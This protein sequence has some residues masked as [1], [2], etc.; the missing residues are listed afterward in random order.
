MADTS[1]FFLLDLV[2]YLL[3]LLLLSITGWV[4]Y[5]LLASDLQFR[6]THYR[7]RLRLKRQ[8]LKSRESKLPSTKWFR[9]LYQLLTIGSSKSDRVSVYAFLG[10][11]VFIGFGVFVL[12]LTR[13]G[14]VV[15]ALACCTLAVAIPYLF[16]SVRARSIRNEIGGS[17]QEFVQTLIHSYSASRADM[18]TALTMTHKQLKQK[19]A[20][21]VLARLVSDLQTAHDDKTLRDVVD[22]FIYSTGN[23]WGMRLGNIVLKSYIYQE[24]VTTAL[25][26]LQQQMVTHQKMMEEEKAEAVDVSLQAILAVFLFPVSLWGAYKAVSPQNW[27]Q[28][29]FDDEFTF[30]SF[31]ITFLFVAISA[32]I[33]FVVRKP[34]NDL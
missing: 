15:L 1:W 22:L 28:L 34:K 29:Q 21:R 24:N 16:I 8:Q 12:I 32:I 10:F 6:Y 9:H 13:I 33:G 11:E 23:S 26:T 31:V 18:Y 20:K 17:M 14:D 7:Y 27:W 3:Y 19:D 2:N 5:V 25:L 4:I 30:L